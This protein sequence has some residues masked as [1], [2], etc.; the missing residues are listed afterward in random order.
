MLTLGQEAVKFQNLLGICFIELVYWCP[1]QGDSFS[2]QIHTINNK[3]DAKIGMAQ[4]LFNLP[5]H[6]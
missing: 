3:T 4:T 5:N 6:G 2:D 1:T